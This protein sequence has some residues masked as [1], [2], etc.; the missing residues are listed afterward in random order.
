[1]TMSAASTPDSGWLDGR[2]AARLLGLDGVDI[3][4]V[5]RLADAGRITVRNLPVRARFSRKDVEAIARVA[6]QPR[7]DNA[8]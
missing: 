1:M 3:R 7:K 4:P 6:M 8:T 2:A 5:R